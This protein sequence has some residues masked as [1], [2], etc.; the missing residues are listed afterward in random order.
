MF[1]LRIIGKNRIQKFLLEIFYPRFFNHV[2]NIGI[3]EFSKFPLKSI[4]QIELRSLKIMLTQSSQSCQVP[5]PFPIIEDPL[6]IET[7]IFWEEPI[8]D[9][10]ELF[11]FY[12][13]INEEVNLFK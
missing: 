4:E 10:F 7:Q 8:S 1:L 2:E 9:K 3:D 12:Q 6:V 5:F 13:D 11:Q